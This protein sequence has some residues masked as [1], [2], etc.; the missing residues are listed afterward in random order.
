MAP[1]TTRT[2]RL[3]GKAAVVV[4]AGQTPGETIGNGRATAILF[5]R[6]GARV[7]C[8]DR[9]LASA[10]ET[11]AM[12]ASEGGRAS[13]F[14]ADITREADCAALVAE[15]GARLGRLDI[16]H[17]NVGIGSGDGSVVRL[18]EADWR[19][20]LDVNLKGMW[21][22]IKHA[23]P[24]MRA[25]G[26]GAIVNISSLAAIAPAGLIAYEVSKAGVNKLTTST[27]ALNARH[28]V[29]CNAI[30]PGLMDTPMAVESIARARGE[31][32]EAV[33]A[34][35]DAR[36]PLG[37]KMGTAW[38]VAYAALFLASDEAKFITGVVLAVDGG[39]SVR[40]G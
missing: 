27:A 14:R 32:R 36:V 30:M 22:T 24:V 9:D 40:F 38:D 5:A 39:A 31:S 35:R 37:G 11:R 10:E 15:A 17:N 18:E 2:G 34:R 6:E 21:L 20:I 23:L 26:G 8:V 12:I 29:R 33:R 3:E 28:G 13:A 4:G 25:Q 1:E 16:L 19:R 7:L